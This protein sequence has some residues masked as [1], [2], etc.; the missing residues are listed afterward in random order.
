LA[1]RPAANDETIRAAYLA[2]I[3]D[4]PPE[5]DRQRFESVRTQPTK[6]F[7]DHRRRVAHQSVRLFIRRSV[8]DLLTRR[9]QRL[10]ACVSPNEQRLLRVLGAK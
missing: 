2:A 10:R 7:R 8:E 3:R 4:S 9:Q 6:R 1:S 5:R